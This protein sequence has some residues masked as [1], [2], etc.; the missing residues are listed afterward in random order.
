MVLPIVGSGLAGAA[1][2][3]GL[4]KMT[5][6]DVNPD[7]IKNQ[8]LIAAM[9]QQADRIRRSMAVRRYRDASAPRP[10]RLA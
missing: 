3:Y 2:G 4:A 6:D 1:G 9:Q 5:S 7:D 8:E 10:P